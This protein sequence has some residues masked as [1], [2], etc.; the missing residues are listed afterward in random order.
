LGPFLEEFNHA[1]IGGVAGE[2]AS[3]ASSK[4]SASSVQNKVQLK[5]HIG[6]PK[7]N[8][9]VA[10]SLKARGALHRARKAL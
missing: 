9:A 6:V 1:Q 3:S 10:L 2:R 7:I 8:G 4:V 5:I